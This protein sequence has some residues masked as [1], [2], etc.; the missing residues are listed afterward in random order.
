MSNTRN[1]GG[2]Q[3]TRF[4]S[5][6]YKNSALPRIT[7]IHTIGKPRPNS[8]IKPRMYVRRSIMYEKAAFY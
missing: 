1:L 8:R 2:N 7:G 5:F 3:G 6:L 4:E